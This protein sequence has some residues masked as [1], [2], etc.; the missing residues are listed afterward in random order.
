MLR[1]PPASYL[2]VFV[3]FAGRTANQ[4]DLGRVRVMK[5]PPDAN[6][7]LFPLRLKYYHLSF[8]SCLYVVYPTLHI[9]DSTKQAISM[10]LDMPYWLTNRP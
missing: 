3:T 1:L 7:Y 8:F 2:A 10:P 5:R 4:K 9:R 6:P